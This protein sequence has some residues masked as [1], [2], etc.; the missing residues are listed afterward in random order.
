[1][2]PAPLDLAYG[3]AADPEVPLLAHAA[4]DEDAGCEDTEETMCVW[5]YHA[6]G[7]VFFVD[8][9]E[10]GQVPLAPLGARQASSYPAEFAH[11]HDQLNEAQKGQ[12]FFQ[13]DDLSSGGRHNGK[14]FGKGHVKG[15]QKGKG[16]GKEQPRPHVRRP[17]EDRHEVR[18]AA[19]LA[20]ARAS[21]PRGAPRIEANRQHWRCSPCPSPRRTRA[22]TASS[23]L[24]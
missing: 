21:A 8:V 4:V 23:S 5:G 10:E 7:G 1:M 14:G 18:A 3:P 17:A 6:F 9:I 22:P 19:S 20:I 15:V 24:P 2:L 16:K 11:V 13:A 12:A